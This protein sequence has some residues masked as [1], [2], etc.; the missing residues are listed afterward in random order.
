MK[1][2]GRPKGGA[3]ISQNLILSAAFD[4]LAES[5]HQGLSMRALAKRLRVTPMALYCHFSGRDSLVWKMSDTVY[6]RVLRAF[7][8]SKGK[9]R[10]QL[11]RLLIL[12]YEA[13]VEFPQLTMLIFT[14]STEYSKE[15]QEINRHLISLLSESNLKIPKRKMWLEIL[16]DFTHGSALATASV[17][18][19]SKNFLATQKLKYRRHLVELLSH[20]F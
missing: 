16:V 3:Q 14:S 9:P 15:L 20:I 19:P 10:S 1:T 8:S 18:H 4:L 11:E 12:Y 13:I 2:R 17:E 6:A 7:E 5:G